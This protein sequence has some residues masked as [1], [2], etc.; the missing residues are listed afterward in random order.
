VDGIVSKHGMNW[1]L[2]TLCFFCVLHVQCSDGSGKVH[3]EVPLSSVKEGANITLK[4]VHNTATAAA[5]V[6]N[7]NIPKVENTTVVKNTTVV[8]N[9]A[10]ENVH[11]D[12]KK[13]G[14]GDERVGYVWM[15]NGEIVDDIEE[16]LTLDDVTWRRTGAYR[17]GVRNVTNNTTIDNSTIL[18]SPDEQ[19]TVL[20]TLGAPSVTLSSVNTTSLQ[21]SW[22]PPHTPN[23]QQSPQYYNIYYKKHVE[24]HSWYK[25]QTHDE[26]V[27]WTLVKLQPGTVYD[28]RVSALN[29]NGEG[30]NS[31]VVTNKTLDASEFYGDFTC[32]YCVSGILELFLHEAPQIATFR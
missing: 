30:S 28:V 19:I 32:F 8:E 16:Q 5:V 27:V 18:W 13:G 1:I 12:V 11:E 10:T 15:F 3:I 31:T 24:Q 17:C 4:C 2:I 26:R 6:E 29:D 9:N 25:V 20:Y 23:L 14:V 22:S 7:T 21:V